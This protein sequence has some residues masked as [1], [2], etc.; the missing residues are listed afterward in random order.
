MKT[1]LRL[2]TAPWL[3]LCVTTA[4]LTVASAGTFKRITIDGSFDDWSGVPVAATDVE[5]DSGQGFD[6]HKIYVANDDQHLYFRVVISRLS[7]ATNYSGF[8][9]QFFIDSDNNPATGLG[10]S[11]MAVEDNYGFSQRYGV[12]WSDGGVTGL[13]YLK[14][15]SGVLTDYQYE[16]RISRSVRDTQAADVPP[17]SG[18][19]ARDLAVFT[20]DAIAIGWTVRTSGWA[21]QDEGPKVSY[22][23]APV[24]PVFTG[25]QTLIDLTSSEGRV[26]SD[27]LDL[28]TDWLAPDYDDSG[29]DWILGPGLY[30][31]D[32]PAG[33]YPA[34]INTGLNGG[35]LTYYMRTHFTWD[36]DLN[37]VGFLLSNYLSA[38]AVIHLNGA[39]L[40][41]IRMPAGS[42]TFDTPATGGPAQPGAAELLDLPAGAVLVGDNVLQV[43]VHQPA[44]AQSSLVFGLS[45]TAS[46]N[47]PPRIQD[48]TQPADRNVTEGQATTFSA[49]LLAGTVPFTFQWFTNGVPIP[50]ATSATFTLD[51]VMN[52]DAG[53]YSVE[54]TNPMGSRVTSRAAVLTTTPIAVVLTDLNLPADRMVAEGSSATFTV[55]ATGT[56]LTYQ[57]FKGAEAIVGEAGSQLILNNVSLNDSG[58]RYSV[59]VSNRLNSVTSR[60]ATLTVVRDLNPPGLAGVTGGG[61]SVVVTF[62]EP[63]D[64]ASAQQAANYS[65]D[66][67]VQVQGAVLDPDGR[68]VTL[69]TTAQ[70]FGQPYK[71]FVNGVQDRFGNAANGTGLF[72]S[73]IAIDGNF[74]DWSNVP[75]ALSQTQNSP[76]TVEYNE[77]SITNDNDYLYLRFSYHD[78]VGPLGSGGNHYYQVFFDTD[79][80]SSNDPFG[81]GE[82][83]I[84]NG[85]VARM[86]GDWTTG[87]YQGGDTALAPLTQ[88]TNFECRVSLR[89]RHETDGSLLF[90]GSAITVMFI[91]RNTSWVELDGTSPRIPYTFATLP[92]LPAPL[93]VRLVGAMVELRWTG[94]GVLERRASLSA[95]DWEPV[96]GAVSG[97]QISPSAAAGFFRLRSE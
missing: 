85:G 73:A 41:R 37:G 14:A 70:S 42:V 46:D 1:N 44:G 10:G 95:G 90:P 31:F 52:T 4:A 43:E 86:G 62:S 45:L 24:P 13:G 94:G 97:I 47:F 59:T 88:S 5:G 50:G 16:C 51:S 91:T 93:I 67:G 12:N 66:G 77:L 38:G 78:P 74:V 17:G 9:H 84:E 82:A 89:A 15:P 25:T 11:E 69:T 92:P 63:V 7:T 96:S 6:L 53:N 20:Q 26:T 36:Y 21:L 19:P 23:L 40:K 27:P 49:G 30:G 75:V 71:L 64:A 32:A 2:F 39:E 57:W 72:R 79:N 60:Q 61:G 55:A 18:N 83:M 58:T 68:T 28:G 8:H 48:P 81:V 33:V 80:D 54:I 34:P 35:A 3:A 22:E 29:F 65:L 87:A 76:G 56:L